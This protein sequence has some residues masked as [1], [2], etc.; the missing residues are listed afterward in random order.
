MLSEGAGATGREAPSH[1]VLR[2]WWTSEEQ[3]DLPQG[4]PAVQAGSTPRLSSLSCTQN[5][6]QAESLLESR[7]GNKQVECFGN[8]NSNNNSDK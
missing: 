4:A 8:N 1:S 3:T 6:V 5:A 7:G 2:V